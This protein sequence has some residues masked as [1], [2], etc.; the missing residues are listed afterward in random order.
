MNAVG[1]QRLLTVKEAAARATLVEST[2]RRKIATGEIPA[3]QVGG[4]GCPLR[5]DADEL[6]A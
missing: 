1:Q 5:V 2:I 4:K 6:D 3:V